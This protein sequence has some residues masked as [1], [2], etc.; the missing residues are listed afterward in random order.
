MNSN[1]TYPN[2]DYK[3]YSLEHLEN[4]LHDAMSVGE[5]TPQEIYDTIK[6]VVEENYYTYKEQTAKAYELLALLNGNGKGH[7]SC[8]KDDP[9]PECK[10][11]WTSFWEEN[12]YPEE[13]EKS[14][15]PKVEDIMP[16]WGHSD[17]E[18]L[19]YTEEELNAMCEKASSDDEKEK[20]REYNLREAE[21][22]DKRAQVDT[23]Y[24]KSK[25]YWD[26]DRNKSVNQ[27]S[28]DEMIAAGYEMTADG[29]WIPSH[30]EEKVKKWVL[31]VEVDGPSGE[32]FVTFPDDLLEAANLKEGDQVEWIDNGEGSYIMKKVTQPIG[33]DEC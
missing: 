24:E 25:Y 12:Y 5:A 33:M 21:Y 17:M 3:K 27:L 16:P 23:D 32:Y 6:K 4:W 30:K 9:S 8:D 7:L 13:Y 10:K 11:S 1:D 20:C 19:R 31:P 15:E 28:Y 22:Y 18:A 14:K 2:L 26:A 29:F